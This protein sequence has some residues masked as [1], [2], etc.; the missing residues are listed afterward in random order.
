LVFFI[1]YLLAFGACHA[2]PFSNCMANSIAI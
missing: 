1:Y 2:H